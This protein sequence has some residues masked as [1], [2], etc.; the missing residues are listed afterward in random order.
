[1]TDHSIEPTPTRSARWPKVL[2]IL[3]LVVNV[4]VIGLYAG[5]ALKPEKSGRGAD[6]QINW[7]IKLVPEERR[8]F[9]KE[10]FREIR[11]DVR[12]AYMQRGDHLTAIAAAIGKDP[13]SVEELESALQARRDGSQQR[14]VLVQ[15]HLVSLLA[16]FTPAERA[17][18]S[19]NLSGFLARLKERSAQ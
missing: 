10:H 18:F 13:F 1:M 14:Q 17:E 6:N 2:L 16:E 15:S 5:H 12:S 3:S 9:T 8:D 7:I 19:E 11:D 4:I